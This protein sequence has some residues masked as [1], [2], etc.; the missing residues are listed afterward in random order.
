MRRSAYP[1]TEADGYPSRPTLGDPDPF[2]E[3]QLLG[4]KRECSLTPQGLGAIH[5]HGVP[6]MALKQRALRL[7]RGKRTRIHL[8]DTDVCD[9]PLS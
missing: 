3:P 4:A 6:R 5:H 2:K 7:T 8:A 9:L 1:K